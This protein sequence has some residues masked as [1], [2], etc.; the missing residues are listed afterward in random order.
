[1]NEKRMNKL[2]FYSLELN[3]ADNR[4]YRFVSLYNGAKGVWVCGREDAIREG[5]KHKALI[6]ALHTTENNKVTHKNICVL[7]LADM[8]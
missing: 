8:L 6:L 1:M 5:E 7:P 2:E 4:F 3:R